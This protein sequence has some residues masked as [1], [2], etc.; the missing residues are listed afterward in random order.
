M[1]LSKALG[2][3]IKDFGDLSI[4]HNP[5]TIEVELSFVGKQGIGGK[6]VVEGNLGE[7]DTGDFFVYEKVVGECLC[8]CVL[9]L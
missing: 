6:A 8:V 5:A 4:S 7:D 2:G 1:T 9:V 3:E